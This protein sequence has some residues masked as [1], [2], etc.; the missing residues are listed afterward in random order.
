MQLTLNVL[1]CPPAVTPET[2]VLTGG[3][4]SLGR[5]PGV[6]WVL[7]DVN[8]MVSRQHCTLAFRSGEWQ[9]LDNSANGTFANNDEA[10]IGKGNKRVLRDHDRLRIG[11][12][13][14]EVLLDQGERP[15]DPGPFV[16][17]REPGIPYDDPF[18]DPLWPEDPKASFAGRTQDDHSSVLDDALYPPSPV[19]QV[20]VPGGGLIPA[21]D[22]L[23]E[24]WDNDLLPG[25]PDPEPAPSGTLQPEPVFAP[26]S[27]PPQLPSQPPPVVAPAP[28]PAA[29]GSLLAAFLAGAGLPNANVADPALAMERLGEAFRALVSGLRSV[30]IARASIKSEFR[31]EQTMIRARNNNP[32]KFAANDDDAVSALLNAGRPTDTTPARAVSDALRDIRLHELATM[33]A[34]QTAVRALLQ[35]LDPDRISATQGQARS[36]LPGHRKVRAWDMYE[37]LHA[38]ISQALSDDFDSVFGKAFARAYEEALEDLA[39]DRP[40]GRR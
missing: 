36:M 40:G 39:R 4:F 23:P 38:E 21:G 32:L 35:R 25:V 17:R 16:A 10:P 13:E 19:E 34:M 12:Y 33:A 27:P 31:I 22:L 8:Q 30:L 7:S 29:D 20:S 1:R 6:D 24:G 15:A 18:G 37:A 2:R 9:L 5:G 26:R 14:I 28:Q 11:P 3:E